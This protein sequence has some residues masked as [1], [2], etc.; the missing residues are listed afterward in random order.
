MVAPS[1]ANAIAGRG[2]FA[3]AGGEN[4]SKRS[5]G[6]SVNARRSRDCLGKSKT[7]KTETAPPIL[8]FTQFLGFYN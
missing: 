6:V 4:A 5:L 2:V 3:P 8:L 1:G 7:T